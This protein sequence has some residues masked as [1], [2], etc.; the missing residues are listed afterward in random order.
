MIF[1]ERI[2]KV[3]FCKTSWKKCNVENDQYFL[4]L[5][6]LTLAYKMDWTVD[7]FLFL[8]L[9]KYVWICVEGALT[10][11]L[12]VL[13]IHTHSPYHHTDSHL[14]AKLCIAI[15]IKD[16]SPASSAL[17]SIKP[18]L[19]AVSL[20]IHSFIPLS[21]GLF[22][23]LQLELIFYPTLHTSPLTL[24]RTRLLSSRSLSSSFT[25]PN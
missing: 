10:S 6:P 23:T 5:N 22:Q 20:I 21:V 19:S 2:L 11:G 15:C 24:T 1:I 8:A 3:L 14:K 25:F 7:P 18:P 9:Q 12:R 17:V 13:C 16:V 4:F